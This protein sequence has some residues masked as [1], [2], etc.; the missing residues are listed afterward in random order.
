MGFPPRQLRA[1]V[2]DD[3]HD[4]ATTL[5]DLL[6]ILGWAVEI[7]ANGHEAIGTARR[8]QPDL[9]ILDVGMPVLDGLAAAPLVR[10]AAPRTLLVACTGWGSERD[11]LK[12]RDAGF[13]LHL[14]KPLELRDLQ[15]VLEAAQARAMSSRR[16][17]VTRSLVR[18]AGTGPVMSVNAIGDGHA[19]CVWVDDSLEVRHGAFSLDELTNV[20][21]CKRDPEGGVPRCEEPAAAPSPAC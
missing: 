14:T 12:T 4:A 11:K 18:R 2:A 9:T 17:I 16:P 15:P 1:L 21:G 5:R 7:A 8:W 13:E 6:E 3:N 20:E 19:Y 10:K